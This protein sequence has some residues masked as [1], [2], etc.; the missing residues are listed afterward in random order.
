MS[1]WDDIADSREEAENLK[2][3]AALIRAIRDRIDGA[4]WSQSI[5]A[6]NLG[7]DTA[8]RVRP[9]PRKDLEILARRSRRD[10][11]EAGHPRPCRGGC[12][13]RPVGLMPS[14]IHNP[15]EIGNQVLL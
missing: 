2:L 4:G 1:V 9:V 10:R 14:S 3:R 7:R 5:A 15:Q 11:I 8:P 6:Q 12:R 13:H